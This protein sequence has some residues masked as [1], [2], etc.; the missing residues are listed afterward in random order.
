MSAPSS[1]GLRQPRWMWNWKSPGRGFE[2]SGLKFFKHGHNEWARWQAPQ[3]STRNAV[4]GFG[5]AT[6]EYLRHRL[7]TPTLRRFSVV[8][9]QAMQQLRLPLGV[10]PSA[11]RRWETDLVGA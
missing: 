1:W 7:P 10:L 4:L 2:R 6:A 3:A 9:L 11:G 5:G 8:S